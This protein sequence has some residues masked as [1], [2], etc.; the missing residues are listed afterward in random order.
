MTFILKTYYFLRY[1]VQW[2]KASIKVKKILLLI[3]QRSCKTDMLPATIMT[4]SLQ[5]FVKV[6]NISYRD[7][8]N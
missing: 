2:Y 5:N 1:S 3:L 6:I 8:F 4:L 7:V